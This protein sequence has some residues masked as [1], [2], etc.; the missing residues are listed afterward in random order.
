M[1]SIKHAVEK[2]ISWR[3]V[4][5]VSTFII[6]WVYTGSPLAGLA[7]GGVDAVIKTI[8]YYLHERAWDSFDDKASKKK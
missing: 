4:A 5:T 6:L 7:I 2:T 3:I 1:S 8:L